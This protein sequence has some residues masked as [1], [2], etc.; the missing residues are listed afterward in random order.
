MCPARK[1]WIRAVFVLYYNDQFQT[2][3]LVGDV[4]GYWFFNEGNELLLFHPLI[5]SGVW[6]GRLVSVV[7]G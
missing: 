2:M 5:Y 4:V 7:N 6:T 1:Y 3:W